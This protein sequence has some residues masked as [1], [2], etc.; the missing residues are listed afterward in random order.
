VHHLLDRPRDAPGRTAAGAAIFSFVATI[1]VAGSADRI[2][3]SFGI[4]YQRQVWLFRI[5]AIVVPIVVFAVVRSIARELR[6]DDWH[7]LAGQ[8]SR[9]IRRS[10]SGGFE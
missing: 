5:A 10:S 7:P 2:F 1:F 8:D 6:D 4:S 9:T 3:V